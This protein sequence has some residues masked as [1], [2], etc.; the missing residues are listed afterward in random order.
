MIGP[1]PGPRR[2]FCGRLH[3]RP[4]LVAFLDYLGYHQEL[5]RVMGST[6]IYT[7]WIVARRPGRSVYTCRKQAGHWKATI[8]P[9]GERKMRRV[10]VTN[11]VKRGHRPLFN[12]GE[13]VETFVPTEAWEIGHRYEFTRW[14]EL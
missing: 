13:P 7:R 12:L 14:E 5:Y 10:E 3:R 1:D 11:T 4:L 6:R 2:F 8:K 9:P